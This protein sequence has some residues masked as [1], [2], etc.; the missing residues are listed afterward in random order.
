[1]PT[2]VA[3]WTDSATAG[4]VAEAL[5]PW[6]TVAPDRPRERSSSNRIVR[7]SCA[8][9]VLQL[10]TRRALAVRAAGSVVRAAGVDG[11][12]CP[13]A[14]RHQRAETI[15]ARAA[16][17]STTIVVWIDRGRRGSSPCS[18]SRPRHRSDE[19][20]PHRC[21]ARVRCAEPVAR[22]DR[23]HVHHLEDQIGVGDVVD[24][25]V[26]SGTVEDVSLRT[27]RLR[28][29]EGVVWHVPNGEIQRVG[30][31]SQQWSRAVLDIPVSYNADIDRA[32]TGDRARPRSEWPT[33]TSGPTASSPRPRCWCRDVHARHGHA[34][35]RR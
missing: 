8:A 15:G 14:R 24:L 30:N 5:S 17:A 29:V 27:T 35:A 4:N 33:T 34:P 7:R 16:R 2:G 23:G 26:A 31:K 9:S 19:R 21:R 18:A 6:V 10:G 11:V 32:P 1:M 12:R 13:T 20:G 3:R 25:G 22:P 28:D